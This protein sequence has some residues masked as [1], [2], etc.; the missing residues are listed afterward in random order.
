MTLNVKLVFITSFLRS[1]AISALSIFFGLYLAALGLSELWIG[2]L[3][4]S[5]LLGMAVGTLIVTK[6]TDRFGR[7]RS[8][9]LLSYIMGIA[10]ILLSQSSDL[11]PL[12]ISSFI[13]MI[14]GMGRDRGALQAIDQSVIAQTSEPNSRTS[15]FAKYTFVTDIGA[16]VGALIAGLPNSLNSYRIAILV[17]GV[18]NIII[19]TLYYFMSNS[20]EASKQIIAKNTISEKSKKI[21]FTFTAL[22]TLDSLGGGFITRSLLTYWFVKRFAVDPSWIGPLFAAA[23]VLNSVAYIVAAKL[24]KKIGLVNT[25]V[26]THIPSSIFLMLV[27]SAPN[28]QIAVILFIL[29]EFFAPMDVPTRQSYLAGVI[30]DHERTAAAGSVNL[31]RNAS[32][33]VGPTLSGWA[34]T[35]AL[36]APLY[37][38][39]MLKIIYDIS[40]WYAF[41]HIRPPEEITSD[42]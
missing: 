20:I 12:V 1:L 19:A 23:S 22:S 15:L 30:S 37:I 3:I 36:S 18:T 4:A 31:A 6:V 17:Y 40:L 27:P 41:R 9:I 28:F 24:A 38:A 35:L 14:N 21:I 29:R 26:F 32:W 2:L 33:V 10:A 13:G 11:L 39:G 8:L 42:E 7:R 16:A 34:M 5:G 25:M